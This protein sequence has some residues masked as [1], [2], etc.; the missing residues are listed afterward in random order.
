MKNLDNISNFK[1][2]DLYGD[3]FLSDEA[4]GAFIIDMIDTIMENFIL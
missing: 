1:R 2:I 4:N 3:G